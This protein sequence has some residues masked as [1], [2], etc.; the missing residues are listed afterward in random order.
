MI[1]QRA[2]I[3]QRGPDAPS[4]FRTRG[5]EQGF[6]SGA[7]REDS[8]GDSTQATRS[9]DS[10]ESGE[11]GRVVGLGVVAQREHVVLGG[12]D[13]RIAQSLGDLGQ[14]VALLGE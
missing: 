1:S 9:G 13:L 8:T 6:Y 14:R 2:L 5:P 10:G 4:G 3:G 7:R 11:P 12:D